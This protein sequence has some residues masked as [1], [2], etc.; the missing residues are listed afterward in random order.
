MKDMPAEN[1]LKYILKN[2]GLTYRIEEDAV[3]VAS[4]SEL[5]DEDIEPRVYFLNYGSGMF[6]EFER[7]VGTGTGLG[8]AASMIGTADEAFSKALCI[9]ITYLHPRNLDIEISTPVQCAALVG[10]GLLFKGSNFRQVTEML[11]SQIGKRPLNSKNPDRECYTL[12]AGIAL[13]IVNL[14]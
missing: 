11:L 14:G 8:G 13:G 10:E 2:Q 6:A 7:T 12:S 5:D 4:P 9:N 3:W 1:A